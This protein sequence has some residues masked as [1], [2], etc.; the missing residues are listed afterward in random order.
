ML[1]FKVFEVPRDGILSVQLNYIEVDTQR[2]KYSVY[3]DW[4]SSRPGWL[5]DAMS[6]V[7]NQ[8]L[9]QTTI[10]GAV[11]PCRDQHP[12]KF[13][14]NS[15]AT[16]ETEESLNYES[17]AMDFDLTYN[18]EIEAYVGSADFVWLKGWGYGKAEGIYI[19]WPPEKGGTFEVLSLKLPTASQHAEMIFCVPAPAQN[20]A[21]FLFIAFAQFYEFVEVS[22]DNIVYRLSSNWVNLGDDDMV[23]GAYLDHSHSEQGGILKETT[24]MEIGMR[25]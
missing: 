16:F 12:Y 10:N 18:S 8:M 2:I 6:D 23:M 24:T 5:Y 15:V 4:Y 9:Q 22:G 1:Q 17:F 13:Y 14:F 3:V 25:D 11:D 7:W 19:P 21:S 20:R